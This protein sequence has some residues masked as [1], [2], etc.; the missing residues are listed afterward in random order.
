LLFR[1]PMV[2]EVAIIGLPHEKWGEEVAAFIRPA[3]GATIDKEEL[4]AYMRTS[5]APHKTPRHWFSVAAFPLTGSGK[6][7]KFKLRESWSKGEV[8]PI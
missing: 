4:I 8:L 1:H 5:L 3:P 7:Q 6:I 2:S